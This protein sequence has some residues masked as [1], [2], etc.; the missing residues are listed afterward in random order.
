MSAL[1]ISVRQRRNDAA[2]TSRSHTFLHLKTCLLF[3]SFRYGTLVLLFHQ[4]LSEFQCG[5]YLGAACAAP[6][7]SHG[8]SAPEISW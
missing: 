5:V 7:L 4:W 1:V 8:V 3:S 6:D 2:L